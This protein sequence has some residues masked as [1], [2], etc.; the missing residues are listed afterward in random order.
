M[1]E[2]TVLYLPAAIPSGF[3]EITGVLREQTRTPYVAFVYAKSKS[4]GVVLSHQSDLLE[5]EPVLFQASPTEPA[6]LRPL[7]YFLYSCVQYW[8]DFNKTTGDLIRS[9]ANE[10]PAPFKETVEAL[11]FVIHDN[12]LI[13]A[14]IR[15][16]A[17]SSPAWAPARSEEHTSELQ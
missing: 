14:C 7:R 13:P 9:S 1:A 16:K 12:K 15:F 10:E 11:V 6:V 5:G 2:K 4:Y 3:G 8:G 17:T